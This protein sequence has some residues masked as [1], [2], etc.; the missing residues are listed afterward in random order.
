MPS[1]LDLYLKHTS[2]VQRCD[3]PAPSAP[4]SLGLSLTPSLVHSLHQTP[5]AEPRAWQAWELSLP[6]QVWGEMHTGALTIT[7]KPPEVLWF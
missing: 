2:Q 6:Y 5:L 1:S 3:K 4:S 7:A